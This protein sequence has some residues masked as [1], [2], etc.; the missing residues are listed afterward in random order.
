[1]AGVDVNFDDAFERLIGHE[2]AFQNNPDDK[3]NWTS[4][5]IGKGLLKGTKYGIS[6]AV[7]PQEDI[8]LL[9]LTRAKELYRRDYWTPAGCDLVPSGIR[10]D[11]F[12]MAVHSGVKTAIKTLQLAVGE[13]RDG[14]L[15][16][17]T[18]AAVETMEPARLM[19]RFNGARLDMLNND[20]VAWS[21]FG[22]GWAQ[23]IAENLLAS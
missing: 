6:A 16:V 21:S 12:D 14:V 17:K 15:G 1:V 9:T 7:Y 13:V 11:L 18:R 22:R 4:G 5:V 23:R 2:G 10:F 3:G 8:K 19:M 20:P